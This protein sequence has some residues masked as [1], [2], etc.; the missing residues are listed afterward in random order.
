MVPL[1]LLA[2]LYHTFLFLVYIDTISNNIAKMIYPL[3]AD[4]INVHVY[5]RVLFSVTYIIFLHSAIHH[6]KESQNRQVLPM[7]LALILNYT[8]LISLKSEQV[9][10]SL[11]TPSPSHIVLINYI[12]YEK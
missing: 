3:L 9:I 5:L 4:L 7:T 10:T 2:V 6:T 8:Y 12:I 1:L 11:C